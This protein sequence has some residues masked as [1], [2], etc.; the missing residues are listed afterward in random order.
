M[1]AEAERQPVLLFLAGPNGAGK[2]TF[3]RLYLEGLGLPFVNADELGL[4]LRSSAPLTADVDR[5]AFNQAE[6]L[7]RGLLAVRASFCTE[8]VFSDPQGAKLEFLKA[9]RAQGYCV[10]LVFIG[11]DSPELS[12]ARVMQRVEAGGHDVPDDRIH[13]RFPRTLDNLRRAIELVDEAALF[14]NSSFAEPFRLVAYYSQG[15]L[16]NR[17]DPLPPWATGLPEL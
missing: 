6:E 3:F 16:V 8:T 11:I 15:K 17:R 7:R 9:A 1:T 5:I 14:D 12:M 13:A 2:S 4:A 10:F